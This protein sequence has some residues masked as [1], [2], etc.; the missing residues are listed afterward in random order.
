VTNRYEAVVE[1]LDARDGFA[2]LRMGRGRL[3]ASLW[4]GVR[5]G[6]KVAVTISPRDVLLCTEHPGRV[7]ARNVLPGRVRATRI[8]PAGVHVEMDVG[9][10]LAALVTRRTAREM[11]WVRGAPVYAVVK[12]MSVTPEAGARFGFRAAAVGKRGLIDPGKMDFLRALERAGSLTETARRM[13]LTYRTAWTWAQGINRAWGGALVA[14]VRGGKGGG[15]VALTSEARSLLERAR[16]W[17][18]RAP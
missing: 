4:E 2:W 13:G 15:G 14:F 17:E 5:A 12:A 10:P 18:S 3:A 8:S 7:S 11:G 1:S 6:R 16:A 9:F